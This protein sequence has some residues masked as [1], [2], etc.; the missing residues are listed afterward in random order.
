MVDGFLVPTIKTKPEAEED[1][2]I[3]KVY[4]TYDDY[5]HTPRL[6]LAGNDKQGRPLNSKAIFEDI[7]AEYQNETV[8]EETHPFLECRMVTVHPCKHS[9]VMKNF[10]E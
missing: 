2:R 1:F 4:I 7:I 6:W 5:Y 9:D 3:Y 10:V 8:T